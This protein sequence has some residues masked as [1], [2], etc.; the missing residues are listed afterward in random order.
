MP[1]DTSGHLIDINEPLVVSR[2][3]PQWQYDH[4]LEYINQDINMFTLLY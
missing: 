2:N 3:T 4:S 1:S